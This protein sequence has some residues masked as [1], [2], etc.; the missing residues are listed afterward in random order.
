M[1][2]NFSL[3]NNDCTLDKCINDHIVID[4]V[5]VEIQKEFLLR[6]LIIFV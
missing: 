2:F 4:I 3:T 1:F 5:I 6:F